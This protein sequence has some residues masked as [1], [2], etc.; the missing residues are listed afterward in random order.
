MHN[1]APRKRGGFF[2]GII[3]GI[4]A[5]N[6]IKNREGDI[7][8]SYTFSVLKKKINKVIDGE[9]ERSAA[10][11]EAEAYQKYTADKLTN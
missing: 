4:F 2:F 1:A 5:Y 10:D 9:L 11:L 8:V 7:R 3:L 6:I